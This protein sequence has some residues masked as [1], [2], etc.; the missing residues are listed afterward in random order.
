MSEVE[1]MEDATMSVREWMMDL[2]EREGRLTPEVV[3]EAARPE[4]SPA[5]S[6]IFHVGIAEA[7]EAHYLDRAHKLI[8]TVKVTYVERPKEEPRRVRFFHAV[9]NDEGERIYEPLSVIVQQVDKFNQVKTAALQRL[10]EAQDSLADLE[11]V[12]QE[13]PRKATI[14]KART[15]MQA[16]SDLV[17]SA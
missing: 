14:M 3:L 7:A 8:Q 4:D 9:T 1:P 10:H 6:Y 17:K 13:A 16:A 12:A 11:Y 15:A 5:H 2:R